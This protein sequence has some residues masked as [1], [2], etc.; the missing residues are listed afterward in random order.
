MIKNTTPYIGKIRLKFEKYPEYR[1]K[2]YGTKMLKLFL[3]NK[4]GTFLAEIKDTN[5]SSIKMV[6]KNDFVFLNKKN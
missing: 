4:T 2:G 3:Q 1:G 5:L 6:E